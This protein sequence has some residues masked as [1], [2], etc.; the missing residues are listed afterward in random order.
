[1]F[2]VK[3]MILS[4]MLKAQEKIV[5]LYEHSAIC[6]GRKRL[7]FGDYNKVEEAVDTWFKEACSTGVQVSGP[8]FQVKA[9]E[10]ARLIKIDNLQD[11]AG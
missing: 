6:P 7:Q 5:K 10:F 9:K 1:M 4:M 3:P 2:D 8:M 11:S